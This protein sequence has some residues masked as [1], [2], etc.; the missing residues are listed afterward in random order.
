MSERRVRGERS[1]P[2]LVAEQDIKDWADEAERGCDVERL[3][4]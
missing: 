1:A 4:K 3:R 2:L